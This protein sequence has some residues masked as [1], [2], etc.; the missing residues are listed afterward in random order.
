MVVETTNLQENS[1][2]LVVE[3]LLCAA[4]MTLSKRLKFYLLM[5]IM[6]WCGSDR[7][8][9]NREDVVCW[10]LSCFELN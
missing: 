8:T 1:S 7:V 2:L 10:L 5:Y 4:L 3:H 6:D 9:R